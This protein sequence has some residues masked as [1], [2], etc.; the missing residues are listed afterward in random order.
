MADHA[1]FMALALALARRGLY[2][3]APNPRVGCVLVR[4]GEIVGQ[5]FH[6]RAGEGHAEVNALREAGDRARGAVAYVSL[7]P[8]AHQ[9]RTPPCAL[10]LIEA[11][12]KEV[13]VACLDPNPLVAGRGVALLK[14]A[15]ISV[16]CGLLEEEAWELNAGFFHR[17]TTGRPLLTVKLAASLDGR[18]A[19]ANGQS[20]W[21]TN[22]E[23]RRDV[24]E[25]RLAS[26][27]ILAGSST[28]IQDNAL[29]TARHATDLP[30]RE[31]LRIV[32]D[33]Q[34]RITKDLRLFTDSSPLLIAQLHGGEERGEFYE[35]RNFPAKDG[36]VD[37][38]ALLDYLGERGLNNLWGEAGP[39]LAGALLRQNL[40]QRLVIYY[41]PCLLG[42]QA[43]PL[44]QLPLLEE[45]SARM[46]FRL[47]HCRELAGDVKLTFKT[48]VYR[49]H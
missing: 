22:A 37:L 16:H 4:D 19:L 43:R 46:N 26:D 31:P 20:Q 38:A 49:N 15:G 35:F 28:V 11:G 45:L 12:I 33:G 24:H 6:R 17:I 44:V 2:S 10:A 47:E 34:G 36:R 39:T 14:E 1:H 48:D 41:A 25:Q 40:V 8:C 32:I 30:R 18:T 21:L 5:G 27:G 3:T 29:L 13:W 23:S 9:G 7:E 42:P